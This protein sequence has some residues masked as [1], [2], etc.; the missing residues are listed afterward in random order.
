MAS[1]LAPMATAWLRLVSATVSLT[2]AT[3]PTN[4][5]AVVDPVAPRNGVASEFSIV[6]YS[7]NWK[8]PR[9]RTD[10]TT[11]DWDKL[12]FSLCWKTYWSEKQDGSLQTKSYE[13]ISESFFLILVLNARWELLELIKWVYHALDSVEGVIGYFLQLVVTPTSWLMIKTST[14]TFGS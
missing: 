8:N 2:A 6:F 5:P 1:S 4:Q 7:T 12:G 9:P 3:P 11:T 13:C 14:T 10:F